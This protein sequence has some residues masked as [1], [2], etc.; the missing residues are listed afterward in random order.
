LRFAHQ[1]RAFFFG[2][3][4][5][6]ALPGVS[7]QTELLDRCK[8]VSE[9]ADFCGTHHWYPHHLVK[10]MTYTDGVKY[11]ADRTGSFWLIDVVGT[12]FFPLP[13]EQPFLSITVT[14]DGLSSEITFT[15]GN[16]NQITARKFSFSTMPVGEWKFY[17]TNEVLFLP[18]ES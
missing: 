18:S 14:S 3:V 9:L 5:F 7:M 10:A 12:E 16:D 15:D 11:F 8:L 6:A 2:T 17:L 1:S 4:F 13:A